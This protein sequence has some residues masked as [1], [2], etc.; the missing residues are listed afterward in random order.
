[1]AALSRT[2]LEQ[3]VEQAAARHRAGFGAPVAV[4]M[5]ARRLVERARSGDGV[6]GL[7]RRHA[8]PPAAL[9]LELS[10]S[11]P[12]LPLDELEPTLAELRGLGVRIALD[13]FGGGH[14]AIDALRRLPLDTVRLDR[15]LVDGLVESPRLRKITA[16][17]LR[18]AG[19]L[20]LASMADGV[21]L[22]EQAAALRAMGCTHGQGTA[23]AG[24]LDEHRL[25]RA[26]ACGLFPVPRQGHVVAPRTERHP[27]TRAVVAAGALPVRRGG[28]SG[29]DPVTHSPLRPHTET[30]VP[31]T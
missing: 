19:D 22:P 17:L 7:L 27:G 14:A 20:G 28:V 10:D 30:T 15:S 3:A 11:D 24:V 29:P 9:L 4:R 25:R 2:L 16:G 18:I 12:P 23:F 6:A 1:V 13:G 5:P 26:L 31:P 8:L 21:D